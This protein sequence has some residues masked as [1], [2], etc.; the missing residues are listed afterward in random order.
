MS[1][2][3]ALRLCAAALLAASCTHPGP[4]LVTPASQ[5]AAPVS[6]HAHEPRAPAAPPEAAPSPKA[7]VTPVDPG[8]PA[9]KPASALL[10][11]I[12]HDNAIFVHEHAPDYFQPFQ[13]GQHPRATVVACADSRFHL[14]A[15]DAAPDGDI[16]EIR[17]IGNQVDG[18][19]GSV[20]YGIYHLHTPLLLIIGHVGCGAIK[21]ALSDY[22]EE[23]V[24]IRRELDGLHL[25][26]RHVV[27][28][29]A[30]P[31][32]QWL[33]GVLANVH[34]QVADAMQE[35]AALVRAGE[36]IVVGAVYD[37][38]G[39]LGEARGKLHFINVNGETDPERLRVSPLLKEAARLAQGG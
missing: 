3:H 16:F 6:I 27:E 34:Q 39:D 5:D 23:P 20:E 11:Q 22:A 9:W 32:Q 15:I 31:E 28:T 17:N 4:V 8:A 33:A 14:Q 25:S 24:P 19:Q 30:P 38:R 2:M 1:L 37:F 7:R 26:L 13:E 10:G 18:N 12:L 35:Y 36:L 29:K 21:A